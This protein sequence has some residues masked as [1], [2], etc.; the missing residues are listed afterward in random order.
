MICKKKI[1]FVVVVALI[2]N[3]SCANK[4]KKYDEGDVVRSEEGVKDESDEI[5][6][7]RA[8]EALSNHLDVYVDSL[9]SDFTLLSVENRE[10][11][12][13]SLGCPKPGLF[14]P[15]VIVPGYLVKVL[16][17]E[18]MYPVHMSDKRAIICLNDEHVIDGVK[19]TKKPLMK[20]K[21]L[22]DLKKENILVR[23]RQDFQE[24]TGIPND[25]IHVVSIKP[26]IWAN[27]A[28]GCPEMGKTYDEKKVKGFRILI[29]SRGRQYTY[30]TDDD[31]KTMACPNIL[32]Y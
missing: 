15:Q 4:V 28:L 21:K 3:L 8:A 31:Q 13:P 17:Q 26:A 11:S 29:E 16:Y 19:K 32:S 20:I 27:S 9:S 22:D 18:K 24:R 10:W 2:S 5:I 1:Y 14:Y 12:N 25:E 7:R 23:T 30:H 6:G